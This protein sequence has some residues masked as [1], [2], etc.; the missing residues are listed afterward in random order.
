MPKLMITLFLCVLAGCAG[1]LPQGYSICSTQPGSY[2]CQIEQ[3]K[4][5]DG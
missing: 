4:N 5:A 3:Y 1:T 2:A